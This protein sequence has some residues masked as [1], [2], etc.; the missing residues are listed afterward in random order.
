VA[1][2]LQ[3][4]DDVQATLD[5]IARRGGDQACEH[6]LDRA[7]PGG[8]HRRVHRRAAPGPWTPPSRSSQGPGL[9]SVRLSDLATERRWQRFTRRAKELGVGSMLS[10]QRFV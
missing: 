7:P 3:Q 4:H 6:L 1:R 8:A 2:S 9:K 5:G 10:V